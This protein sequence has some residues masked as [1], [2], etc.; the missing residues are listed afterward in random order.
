MSQQRVSLHLSKSNTPGSLSPLHRLVSQDVY[1]T[2]RADL[3]LVGNHVPQA[4]V[5]DNTK[6]DVRLKF[7]PV[8]S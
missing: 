6:K 3:K 2:G 1:W 4:L 5:V 8:H 7:P